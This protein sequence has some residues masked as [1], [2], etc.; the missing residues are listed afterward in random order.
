RAEI[1]ARAGRSAKRAPPAPNIPTIAESGMTGFEFV[2]WYGLWGPK[3][4]AADIKAKLPREVLKGLAQPDLKGRLTVLGFEGIGSTPA[5]FATFIDQESA[6][7][8]QI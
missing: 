4:L 7:Y 8:Q 5:A 1:A 6:K 3:A 2:S